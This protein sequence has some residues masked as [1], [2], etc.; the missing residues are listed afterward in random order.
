MDILGY[1]AFGLLVLAVLVY[2]EQNTGKCSR[3]IYWFFWDVDHWLKK[4]FPWYK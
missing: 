4:K 1:I 3:T 2:F